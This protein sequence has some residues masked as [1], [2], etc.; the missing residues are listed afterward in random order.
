MIHCFESRL[1][2]IKQNNYNS[3]SYNITFSENKRTLEKVMSSCGKML[4]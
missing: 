4:Q 3:W 2:E 1:T